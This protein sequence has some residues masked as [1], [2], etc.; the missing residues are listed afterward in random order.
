MRTT[1]IAVTAV[2]AL[3]LALAGCGS[4]SSDGNSKPNEEPA[5]PTEAATTAAED[6]KEDLD[7]GNGFT[8]YEA[9]DG[10]TVYTL[11]LTKPF[12][13][14]NDL[15]ERTNKLMIKAITSVEGEDAELT[16]EQAEQIFQWSSLEID[17]TQGSAEGSASMVPIQVVGDEMQYDII[18]DVDMFFDEMTMDYTDDESLSSDAYNEVIEVSNEW[19]DQ[20]SDAKPGVKLEVPVIISDMPE[21]VE[22]VWF[23]DIEMQPKK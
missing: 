6:T 11:D 19:I 1:R 12:D 20:D 7:Q 4:G 23:G 3:T 2:A 21:A 17:N 5:D 15:I 10:G 14:T 13:Y 18:T 16:E 22:S 8:V 9:S